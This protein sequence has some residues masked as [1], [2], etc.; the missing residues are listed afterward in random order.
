MQM[1][2]NFL[3]FFWIKNHILEFLN[4]CTTFVQLISNQLESNKESK[5]IKVEADHN[6]SYDPIVWSKH[7]ASMF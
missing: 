5:I 2:L 3:F 4:I 6:P 7:V 1:G